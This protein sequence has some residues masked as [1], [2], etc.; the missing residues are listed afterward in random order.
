[1]KKLLVISQHGWPPK[2]NAQIIRL[3]NLIKNLPEHGWEPIVVARK[4]KKYEIKDFALANE[5]RG[6]KCYRYSGILPSRSRIRELMEW[7]FIPDVFLMDLI[8]NFRKIKKIIIK[9]KPDFILAETPASG[10]IIG[11]ILGKKYGIKTALGYADP[12]TL[13]YYY[14]PPTPIHHAFF[15][16][17]ERHIFNFSNIIIG[18]SYMQ[19]E[20]MKKS[21]ASDREVV[22]IPNG[23]DEKEFSE[24]TSKKNS[25]RTVFLYV[26]TIYRQF[27]LHFLKI[28]GEVWEENPDLR[29]KF[30]VRFIGKI[31]P[32]KELEIRKIGEE[33][34]EIKGRISTEE[35]IKE[36]T[37]VDVNILSLSYGF[38]QKTFSSRITQFART[39]KPTMVFANG[40]S[41]AA[42]V[43]LKAGVGF[44][45]E[46]TD[47]KKAKEFI[48]K[49]IEEKID[50]RPNMEYIMQFEWENIAKKLADVL[51][52]A[53]NE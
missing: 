35:L 47:I 36:R 50:V 40:D 28:F 15:S 37:N 23:F 42:E 5:V 22:W 8:A 7:F 24:K 38:S 29:G 14:R 21:F 41:I 32:T 11:S 17:L 1:M 9:E 31:A 45:F 26:G 2:S 49:A 20:E 6:I 12:W 13:N 16:K 34:I 19:L 51:E 48:I 44:V 33:F 10:L 3:A 43:L 46:K 52:E 18:A 4:T 27:D 53:A 30:V 39:G 25:D